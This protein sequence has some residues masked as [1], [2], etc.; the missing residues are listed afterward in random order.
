MKINIMYLIRFIDFY[1]ILYDTFN[2]VIYKMLLGFCCLIKVETN[3][4][5]SITLKFK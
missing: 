4:F 5:V 3:F 1:C 2:V